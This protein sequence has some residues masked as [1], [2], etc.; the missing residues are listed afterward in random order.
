MEVVFPGFDIRE[1]GIEGVNFICHDGGQIKTTGKRK[2]LQLFDGVSG[3]LLLIKVI[4]AET[5]SIP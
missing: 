2:G 1:G 4:N 3:I 5:T